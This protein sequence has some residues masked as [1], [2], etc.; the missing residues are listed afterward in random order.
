M[1]QKKFY[2]NYG[3]SRFGLGFCWDKGVSFE[4]YLLFFTFGVGLLNSA[5]GFGVWNYND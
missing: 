4:I 5:K 2:I 3:F 1:G